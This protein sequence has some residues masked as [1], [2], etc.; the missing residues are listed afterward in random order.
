MLGL[1]AVEAFDVFA[2]TDLVMSNRDHDGHGSLNLREFKSALDSICL[3]A[4]ESFSL[5]FDLDSNCV[6]CAELEPAL[7]HATVLFSKAIEHTFSSDE[8]Q[9]IRP[10]GCSMHH[11]AAEFN[12]CSRIRFRI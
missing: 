10:V 7:K 12:K 1:D 4:S 11:G 5:L 6:S 3:V 9:P 2:L 8:G